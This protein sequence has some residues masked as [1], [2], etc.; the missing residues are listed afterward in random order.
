MRPKT[1]PDGL[2]VEEV[3]STGLGAFSRSS[4]SRSAYCPACGQLVAYLTTTRIVIFGHVYFD[5]DRMNMRYCEL[6]GEYWLPESAR[7]PAP[8]LDAGS[9]ET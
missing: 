7:A 1:L 5:H 9:R 4:Q 2:T 3:G 8:A 6:R